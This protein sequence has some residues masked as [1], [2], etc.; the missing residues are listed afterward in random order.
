VSSTYYT[1]TLEHLLFGPGQ[2]STLGPFLWLLL[3]TLIV[4][5]LLPNTPQTTLRSVD[6]TIINSDIGEAFVDDS[7]VG[8]TSSYAF[9]PEVPLA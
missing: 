4:T 2:G 9:D 6:G 3:F 8:C 7:R 1:S 5:S